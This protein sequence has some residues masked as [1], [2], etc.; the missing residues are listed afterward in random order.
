MRA[1]RQEACMNERLQVMVVDDEEIVGRR[2]LFALEQSG[3]DVET[4]VDPKAALARLE[5]REFDILVTDIRMQEV[6]GI[7]ILEAAKKRCER[8]KVVLITAYATLE[9][10][11]EAMTKGVF[12]FLAKPFKVTEFLEVMER[13]AAAARATSAQ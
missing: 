2:L 7:Q 8:T 13:A 11:R 6:D 12:D 1:A 9:V 5:E 4:F 3:Y 10:A